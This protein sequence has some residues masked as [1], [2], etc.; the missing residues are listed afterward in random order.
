MILPKRYFTGQDSRFL[1]MC[2]TLPMK[3]D[4]FCPQQ[5]GVL[6]VN[7]PKGPTSAAC[8]SRIKRVLGQKKIG[9][10]G[11][12]DPMASGVLL[13]LLGSGTKL[14]GHLMDSGEKIYA[15]TV[16]LGQSTDTWDAEGTVTGTG[17]VSHV[18]P[19][20][21]EKAVRAFIGDTE[22]DVPP[23]SAAKHE[24]K[25]LYA[26]ARKGLA[27]PVK[28]KTVRVS[29]AEIEWVD[30]PQFRFRV[31]CGSGTYIRSLAHSLGIRLG[32]GA[33]LTELTRKYSHPFGLD[34]AHDLEDVLAA[35]EALA[36]RVTSIADALPA[37]PRV[38]LSEKETALVKNGT[39][40]P[41]AGREDSE[42]GTRA[43]L[44]DAQHNALALA[45]REERP[46]GFVWAV[47]RG[48]WI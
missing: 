41:L 46:D 13:V 6:V 11:T 17:D 16:L 34:A 47:T 12:L 48:L 33:T 38:T 26:L 42:T 10:A 18:T 39:A 36:S 27:T 37:W 40:L 20:M 19:A 21:L 2:L 32:C 3:S 1:Y 22:Q 14:S 7:K 30:L 44:L 9:H 15:G 5:H 24:G 23:Y 31:T 28:T 4:I 45:A 29:H 8:L 43:L 25:P 35:P